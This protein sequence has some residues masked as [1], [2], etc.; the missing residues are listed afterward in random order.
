MS[1]EPE[2]DDIL[3]LSG[4][5][6]DLWLVKVPKG[7]ATKWL[8]APEDCPVGKL[9]FSKYVFVDIVIFSPDFTEDV[10]EFSFFY[11]HR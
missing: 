4:A 6:H 11:K 5:K 9:R 1:N 8:N 2:G 7:L 10:L 3:D